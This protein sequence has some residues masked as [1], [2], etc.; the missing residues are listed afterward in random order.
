[1]ADEKSDKR[2]RRSWYAAL[3]AAAGAVALA[4]IQGIAPW[5]AEHVRHLVSGPDRPAAL[6]SYSVSRLDEDPCN[7]AR[8]FVPDP[9]AHAVLAEGVPARWSDL[10]KH[11]GAAFVGGSMVEVSIQGE[12]E[13][14]ITLTGVHFKVRHLGKRPPGVSFGSQCGGGALGR[15]VVANIDAPHP[16]LVQSVSVF[17]DSRQIARL[18]QIRFPWT[19]SVTDPLLLYVGTVTQRC[20]C[21]WRARIPWVSGSRRGVI[22]IGRP[23]HGYRVTGY[24]DLPS[25]YGTE[26]GWQGGA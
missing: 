4:V 26:E 8:A 21:E 17:R 23:G 12:S 5:S 13:R 14:A 11:R 9:A 2:R 16:R 3:G 24:A 22:A 10:F 19:V 7:G 6:I 20:F 25:Y 18:R 1:M 15:F